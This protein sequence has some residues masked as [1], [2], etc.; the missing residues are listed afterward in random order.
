MTTEGRQIIEIKWEL[1][2]RGWRQLLRLEDRAGMFSPTE[3]LR[4]VFHALPGAEEV[5]M[6]SDGEYGWVR[7][8]ARGRTVDYLRWL[9]LVGFRRYRRIARRMI[10]DRVLA[11][12]ASVVEDLLH[13]VEKAGVEAPRIAMP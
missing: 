13:V 9:V 5:W 12:Q 11:K 2:E 3:A 8:E 1:D 6:D 7:F 10:K 4:D